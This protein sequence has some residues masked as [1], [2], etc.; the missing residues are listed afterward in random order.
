MV[1]E[2]IGNSRDAHREGVPLAADGQDPAAVVEI[3]W[4]RSEC[5]VKIG[6]IIPGLDPDVLAPDVYRD[7]PRPTSRPVA[8]GAGDPA[9]RCA[10]LEGHR[11]LIFDMAFRSRRVYASARFMRH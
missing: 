10:D 1:I 3:L 6:P 5:E 11:P 4:T 2:I 9:T 8:P 7:G